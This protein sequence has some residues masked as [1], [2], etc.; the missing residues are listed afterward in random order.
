MSDI[1]DKVARAICRENCAFY[2][3]PP[4]WLG[5]DSWPND[6]CDSPGCQALAVAAIAEMD[7]E[8]AK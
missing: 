4:C 7:E 1:Q 5:G 6:G 2:G 3:E 8:K